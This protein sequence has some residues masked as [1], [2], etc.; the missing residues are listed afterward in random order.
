MNKEEYTIATEV[1]KLIEKLEKKIESSDPFIRGL[2]RI[3][4]SRVRA[5]QKNQ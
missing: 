1:E 4:S 5:L 2:I 3:L